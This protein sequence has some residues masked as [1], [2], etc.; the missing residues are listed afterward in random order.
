MEQPMQLHAAPTLAAGVFA[1][2][3]LVTASAFLTGDRDLVRML[4]QGLLNIAVGV[5]S[6]YFGSS[7]GSRHK[8]ETIAAALKTPNAAGS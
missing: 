6:Y 3:A 4:A 2:L 1:L 7:A 8:D 5:A